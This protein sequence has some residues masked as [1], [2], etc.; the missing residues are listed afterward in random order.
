MFQPAP[1]AYSAAELALK[2]GVSENHVRRL[3]A[4]GAVRAVR[5]GRLVRIPATELDRLLAATP[6]NGAPT[7]A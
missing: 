2:L 1:V 7:A 6:Q 3:I 4:T 5:L